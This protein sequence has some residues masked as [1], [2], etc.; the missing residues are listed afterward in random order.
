MPDVIFVYPK[1]GLDMKGSIDIPLSSLSASSLLTKNYKVKIIDQRMDP[2]WRS[3]LK[4]SLIS[5]PLFVGI[6]SMTGTQIKFALEAAKLVKENSSSKV[7]FGGI[8]PTLLPE[9]TLQHPLIDIVAVREGEET[10]LK[11]A[12]SLEKNTSLTK[13]NSIFF[14]ENNKIISTK[15]AKSLDL[16]KL[17]DLPYALLD[18]NSYIKNN[19]SLSKDIKRML[20]FIS[21][22]GC[23]N[24]CAFCCNPRLSKRFWRSMTA[25]L[26]YERLSNLVNT[27]K[28]DGILFNDENYLTN[29]KRAEQISSLIKNKFKYSI[30]ARMDD[31]L[32]INLREFEKKG[33]SIVEPGI[34]SGSDRILKL[35]RKGETTQ[36]D[37][38]ANKALSKTNII[39]SYNFMMGFPT[40]TPQ[41]LFSTTD[42]ALRLIKENKNAMIT[43]FY[44]FAPY[45]GTELYELAIKQGF[46][47][48]K[49]LEAW[50]KF[51]RQHL[52][53]PWIQK[54]LPILKN[55]MYTSKLVDGR[56]L[57][58]MFKLPFS[59]TFLS[60]LGKLYQKR[61]Q[62]HDFKEKLDIFLL[63]KIAKYYFKW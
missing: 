18:I 8:H 62:E 50:S 2:N 49:T 10:A 47:P 63:D 22:R 7:I 34:E 28:L 37:L 9:Q 1:T 4:K 20:P 27:Y 19:T 59:K 11:I 46:N 33:L 32:K 42:L 53:T 16:N 40:E 61:W 45:P 38:A 35:I 13:V 57:K 41:E 30:Q 39:A 3:T 31:L 14:K 52:A 21:S 58:D 55:I 60:Y 5:N 43:G 24:A 51:S 25:E 17:P 44:V 29:P 12:D 26:T 36:Q 54:N 48:P 23:P 6:S 15:P 56:R